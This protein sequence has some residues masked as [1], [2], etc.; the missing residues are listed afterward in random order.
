MKYLVLIPL[1]VAGWLLG[2]W[3]NEWTRRHGHP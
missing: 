2:L 1:I 3:L